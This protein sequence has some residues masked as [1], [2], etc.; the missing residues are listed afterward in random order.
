MRP[1]IL[2]CSLSGEN[3]NCWKAGDATATANE[4]ETFKAKRRNRP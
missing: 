4:G 1:E 2:R 3:G